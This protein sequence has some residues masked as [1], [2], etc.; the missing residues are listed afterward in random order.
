MAAGIVWQSDD[1]SPAGSAQPG[2]GCVTA[3]EKAG[4]IK[5]RTIVNC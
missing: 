1:V 4:L 5:K 3:A 2:I